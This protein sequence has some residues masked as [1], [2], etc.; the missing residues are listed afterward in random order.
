MTN[1]VAGDND[2]AKGQR[3]YLHH[4]NIRHTESESVTNT[5]TV[6]RSDKKF[7]TLVCQN[8]PKTLSSRRDVEICGSWHTKEMYYAAFCKLENKSHSKSR[9]RKPV[10]YCLEF[11]SERHQKCIYLYIPLHDLAL[12]RVHT[13]GC[14]TTRHLLTRRLFCRN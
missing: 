14:E 9:F 12:S 6:V 3:F 11:A 10:S 7:A 1:H 2:S 5:N 4:L 8:V 13:E